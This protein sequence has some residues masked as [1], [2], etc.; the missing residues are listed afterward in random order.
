MAPGA[1]LDQRQLAKALGVSRHPVRQA[2][3]LLLDQGVLR[4]APERRL[5]AAPLDADHVRHVY[6]IRAVIERLACRRAGEHSAERAPKLGPA[7]I[8]AGRKAVAS[9]SVPMVASNMRFHE[10][11][12]VLSGNPLVVPALVTYLAYMQRVMGEVLSRDEKP[13]DIWIPHAEILDAIIGGAGDRAE[14]LVRA[15]L[16]QAA[17]F[18]VAR[19]G[20]QPADQVRSKPSADTTQG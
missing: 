20:G 12:Y 11:I 3:T 8:D 5:M 14:T 2:L 13:R 6:D 7:L 19:L 10:F 18:M 1:R 4:D 9:G 17:G 16:T 15:H